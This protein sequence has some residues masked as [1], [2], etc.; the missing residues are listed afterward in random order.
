MTT[1]VSKAFFPLTGISSLHTGSL[2]RDPILNI[3][4][5]KVEWGSQKTPYSHVGSESRT[6]WK[7]PAVNH[8]CSEESLKS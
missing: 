6:G 7:T 1:R 3:I 2:L 4:L 5:L 8:R